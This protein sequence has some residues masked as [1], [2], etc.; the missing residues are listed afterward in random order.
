M[1]ALM[2]AHSAKVKKIA[3]DFGDSRLEMQ[4]LP[5]PRPHLVLNLLGMVLGFD[6]CG[7]AIMSSVGNLIDRPHRADQQNHE[8]DGA[9]DGQHYTVRRLR[10]FETGES[11][12]G[13]RQNG[14]GTD[15]PTGI[16]GRPLRE[17]EATVLPSPVDHAAARFRRR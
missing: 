10:L 3:T 13:A 12:P 17:T 11:D 5:Q 4:V 1:R 8:H 16:A 7:L 14:P 6:P 15:P 2:T 9:H